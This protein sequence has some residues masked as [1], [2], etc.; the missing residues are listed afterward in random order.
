MILLSSE[1]N[2]MSYASASFL[3]HG[4]IL[5][6]FLIVTLCSP[7][8]P[9]SLFS[10]LL[11]SLPLWGSAVPFYPECFPIEPWESLSGY[12]HPGIT[13][14]AFWA[15]DWLGALWT[16][17]SDYRLLLGV[18]PS[19]TFV[20]LFVIGHCC[21]SLGGWLNCLAFTHWLIIISKS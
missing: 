17:L 13:C 14:L 12:V 2:P 10:F 9:Y 21:D 7:R 15:S 5:I 6:C 8:S 11:L 4:Y 3:Q 1:K 20:K 18:H 19:V 16:S